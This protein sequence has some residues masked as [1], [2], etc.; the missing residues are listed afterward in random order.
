M[1][2][3]ET[4]RAPERTTWVRLGMSPSGRFRG[5]RGMSPCLL[6]SMHSDDRLRYSRLRRFET[7]A[8]A[9]SCAEDIP[10]IVRLAKHV[11][12][13]AAVIAL[14]NAAPRLKGPIHDKELARR[15]LR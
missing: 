15:Q 8:S 2:C 13:M 12:L 4:S 3:Q 14:V 5:K 7:E 1:G 9:G 6:E 10:C 11:V